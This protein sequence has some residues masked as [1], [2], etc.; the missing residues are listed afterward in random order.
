MK[1]SASGHSEPTAMT[2]TS[3]KKR[4]WL[5]AIAATVASVIL[6]VAYLA[7]V[8]GPAGVVYNPVIDPDEFVLQVNNTFYP[9]VPGTTYIY[10][11]M[12]EDGPERNEVRVTSDTK[13]VMGVTCIVVWDRVWL[14]GSLIEE[15]YDWYA[16]DRNGS[17]WYFGEDSR[18]IENG[19]IVS[20]EGSWEAGV[21]GAEPGIVMMGLP[22]VGE[23]Y[24]Q[25][26]YKGEA[27]DM[28]LVISLNSSANVP[29]GDFV[30]CV[31]TK[32]WTPL[33]PGVAEF[34]YYASGIGLVREE[35]A[36]GGVGYM[37]LQ[38]ILTS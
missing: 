19:V 38:E 4:H 13:L 17:V 21:D 28:A 6:V 15:T 10:E 29:Y 25:E 34:K 22:V 11:G 9:L 26:Y 8:F 2:G 24:R 20:T 32:D 27:E 12:S 18:E 1:I 31:Q 36:S 23:Q 7:G 14:N 3:R 5:T 16:Q 37:S 35:D 33:E 30:N